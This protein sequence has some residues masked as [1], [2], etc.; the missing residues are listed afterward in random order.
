MI[1]TDRSLADGP[2]PKPICHSMPINEYTTP[3]L[4]SYDDSK[5]YKD[6]KEKDRSHVIDCLEGPLGTDC[7]A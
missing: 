7:G 5:D 3:P 1:A 4:S 6:Y 2:S